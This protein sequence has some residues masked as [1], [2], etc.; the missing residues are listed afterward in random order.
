MT[1]FENS[2]QA[3]K[4][5]NAIAAMEI[6]ST[7]DS[8]TIF[9]ANSLGSKA[10][11]QYMKLVGMKY[12]QGVLQPIIHEIVSQNRPCELDPTRLGP[13]DNLEENFTVLEAYIKWCMDRILNSSKDCPLQMRQVFHALRGEAVAQFPK[14]EVISCTVVTAFI[15]LR[16]FNA[17]ILGPQLFGLSPDN[18]PPNERNS[19]TFT[20][21]SKTIQ[22]LANMT[23]FS[24]AKEPHMVQLNHLIENNITRMK[25]F[26]DELCTPVTDAQIAKLNKKNEGSGF[27]KFFG[28]KKD[29]KKGDQEMDIERQFSAIHRQLIRNVEK[30]AGQA[31]PHETD[32]IVKL[33]KILTDMQ[34]V[35]NKKAEEIQEARRMALLSMESTEADTISVNTTDRAA[36]TGVGS[37][38]AAETLERTGQLLRSK[39]TNGI[40]NVAESTTSTIQK[41]AEAADD[42]PSGGPAINIQSE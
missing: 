29:K 37:T 36:T 25:K 21:I 17:A 23:P 7:N 42:T 9:R 18:E 10:I 16:F 13:N 40:R 30:M 14:D 31:Q 8:N 15:F 1:I 3:V 41:S 27:A 32:D 39:S 11:D 2:Q 6:R 22:Q 34:D 38:L 12:L 24:K 26:L 5:L 20:L 33:Q 19:R 4:F 35:Y 28:F